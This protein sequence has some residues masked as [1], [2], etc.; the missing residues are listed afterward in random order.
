MTSHNIY[1]L[2]L[3]KVDANGHAQYVANYV[4]DKLFTDNVLSLMTKPNFNITCGQSEAF[5]H[6]GLKY[7]F[8]GEND[9]IVYF[10]VAKNDYPTRAL[11]KCIQDLQ[12]YYVHYKSKGNKIN[13]ELLINICKKY[14]DPTEVDK[15]YKVQ[16][17]INIIKDTMQTN[18]EQALEN[19]QNLEE[20]DKQTEEL[21]NLAGVFKKGTNQLKNKM[22]WKSMKMNFIIGA[23]VLIILGVIAGIIAIIY[24]QK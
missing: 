11:S 18:I 4:N 19:C 6:N 16:Q 5:A 12:N 20:I 15:V 9:N 22:W 10:I 8:T 14:D 17:K 23:I 3:A 2:G 7:L 21:Q 1:T 24:Q 13:M